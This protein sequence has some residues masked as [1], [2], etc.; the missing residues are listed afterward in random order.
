MNVRLKIKFFFTFVCES[1]NCAYGIRC[2]SRPS[3]RTHIELLQY[4]CVCERAAIEHI[5]STNCVRIKYFINYCQLKVLTLIKRLSFPLPP[6]VIIIFF[7]H[8]FFLFSPVISIRFRSLSPFPY[9]NA[10]CSKL[11]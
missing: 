7:F 10:V 5:K 9:S 11:I 2:C 6:R 1:E 8:F 3:R 4:V